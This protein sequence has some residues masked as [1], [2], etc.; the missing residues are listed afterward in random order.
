MDRTLNTLLRLGLVFALSLSAA[1]A[2]A[3][4]NLTVAAPSTVKPNAGTLEGYQAHLVALRGLLAACSQSPAACEPSKVGGDDR[5]PAHA[6]QPEFEVHW[7]WLWDLVL[8]AKDPKLAD[9]DKLLRE[10]AARLKDQMREAGID[11]GEVSAQPSQA[12]FKKA[13]RDADNVLAASEFR[14]VT[15]NGFWEQISAKLFN[16]LGRIFGG[17]SNLGQRAPWIGPAIMYGF[18]LLAF[19]GLLVW[20]LRVLDRQRLAVRLESPAALSASQEISRSWAKL[21]EAAASSGEWREAV[22]ALYWA[23]VSE[24]EGRRIWRQSSVRTPREYLRLVPPEA[25]QYRPLRALTQLLERIW[26]GL[27]PADC[28]DYEAALAVYTEL[29]QA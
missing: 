20:V 5:V 11:M 24:L 15:G 7:S 4:T 29:R 26:Y 18:L 25:P 2:G 14:H 3:Q 16:W 6:G 10:A 27:A 12:D 22:H 1:V 21:A 9:R 23:S 19:A 13:R 28:A 8:K 17:V